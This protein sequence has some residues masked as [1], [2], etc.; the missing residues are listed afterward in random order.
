MRFTPRPIVAALA[1]AFAMLSAGAWGSATGP[2]TTGNG[3]DD[4]AGVE[5]PVQQV[6]IPPVQPA[7]TQ[8]FSVPADAGSYS[9]GE[10][11]VDEGSGEPKDQGDDQGEDKGTGHGQSEGHGKGKGHGLGNTYCQELKGKGGPAF[12]HC[13]AATAHRLHGHHGKHGG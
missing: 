10:A 8:T 11:P 4:P 2:G 13:I 1:V 9:V 5:D 7:P 3:G 12:G 6:E